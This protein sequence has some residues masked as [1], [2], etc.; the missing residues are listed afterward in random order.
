MSVPDIAI[1]PVAQ[2][3]SM[4]FLNHADPVIRYVGASWRAP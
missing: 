1:E 3:I 2:D 4:R